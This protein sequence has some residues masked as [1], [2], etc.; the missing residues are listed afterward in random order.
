M[1]QIAVIGQ[2]YVGLPLAI[3]FAQYFSVIGYDINKKRIADLA[4][5]IDVTLEAD[6]KKFRDVLAL[7]EETSHKLGYKPTFDISDLA[8]AQVYIITVPT[9]VDQ[10]NAPDL[11]YLI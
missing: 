10:Y 8:H 11:S 4:Q 6:V 1:K 7:G 3:E 2:G 9:P 5:G